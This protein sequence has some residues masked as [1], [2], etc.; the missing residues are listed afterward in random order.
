MSLRPSEGPLTFEHFNNA[1]NR[2]EGACPSATS[3]TMDNP[4]VTPL[5]ICLLCVADQWQTR[6]PLCVLV[7]LLN[8]AKQELRIR[9]GSE[10]WPLTVI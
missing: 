8:Q 4:F 1:V 2:T 10:V 5:S 3:T 7:S 6:S 9:R